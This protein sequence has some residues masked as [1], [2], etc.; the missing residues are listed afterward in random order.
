MSKGKGQILLYQLDIPQRR[1]AETA[2]VDSA[3]VW[4]CLA[5]RQRPSKRLIRA[6]FKVTGLPAN[7]L[8][9]L[10]KSDV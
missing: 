1:I 3:Y 9:E 7:A 2:E 4:R 10:G 8:F 5:G 6:A